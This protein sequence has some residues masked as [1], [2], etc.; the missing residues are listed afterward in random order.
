MIS[1]AFGPLGQNCA[2]LDGA[3]PDGVKLSR[4]AVLVSATRCI[5]VSQIV[6]GDGVWLMRVEQKASEGLEDLVDTLQ[7]PS[8]E[9][10][11]GVPV[12]CG[13][14]GQNGPVVL[15]VTDTAGR[16]IHPLL[17][18][19]ACGIPRLATMNTIAGLPWQ[20]VSTTQI[21]QVKTEAELGAL[22][23][24]NGQPA[25]ALTAAGYSIE[26][27]MPGATPMEHLV[28]R[29]EIDLGNEF[30]TPDSTTL[31]L[32]KPVGT[33]VMDAASVHDLFSAIGSDPP[34]G[35]IETQPPFAVVH[36]REICSKPA[37]EAGFE[38][39]SRQ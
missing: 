16:E 19:Q 32:G 28:C 22:C 7:M 17:P 13:H 39:I 35:C 11:K 6:P 38:E 30:T 8:L 4:D 3:P 25:I 36:C 33:S 34:D 29:Y 15:S 10:P 23:A 21:Q 24:E 5:Y 20:V 2:E 26:S 14:I 37:K 31:F 1:A 27:V 9:N 18:T 12:P